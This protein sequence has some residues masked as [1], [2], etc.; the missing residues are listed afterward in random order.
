MLARIDDTGIRD[1]ARGIWDA[2]LGD[3]RNGLYVFAACGAVVAAAASSL[4][5]PVD[6]AD[7]LRRGWAAV[8][9]VPGATVG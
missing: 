9:T 6:V 2:Y 5:R 4:L 1:A 8:T 3:L 7:P